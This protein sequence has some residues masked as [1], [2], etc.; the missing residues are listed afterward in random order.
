MTS[1][2]SLSRILTKKRGDHAA[3]SS[4]IGRFGEGIFFLA[5]LLV[6][7]AALLVILFWVTLPNW[8]VNQHFVE[9]ECRIVEAPRAEQRTGGTEGVS[10]RPV[11]P[12]EYDVEGTTYRANNYDLV[13]Q[14]LADR[15]SAESVAAEFQLNET[16]ACWYDPSD[17]SQVVLARWNRFSYWIALLLPSALIAVGAGGLG[18]TVWQAAV[19]RERRAA[20]AQKAADVELFD[21][22]PK[23]RVDYP[24]IPTDDELKNS[25]GTTLAYR[26]PMETSSGWKMFA[27]ATVCVSWNCLVVLFAAVNIGQHLAGQGDWNSTIAVVAFAGAGVWLIYQVVRQLW[28]ASR[29]APTRVEISEHPL[30]PG[31]QCELFVAQ[32]G[33]LAV[34]RFDVL[35]VCEEEATF[36]QGTDTV[37]STE[38]VSAHALFSKEQFEID[39]SAPY[40]VRCAL[41]VPDDAMHSFCADHNNVQWKLLVRS[42]ANC[43][44]NCD[45][46]FPIVVVPQRDC[47]DQGNSESEFKKRVSLNGDI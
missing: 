39:G 24:T 8:R 23:E 28:Q 29:T 10:Y 36:R 13:D 20:L 15:E 6:G 26:L 37:T 43:R 12:F 34:K 40:E 27:L 30:E 19:S 3:I 16:Y 17:P 21:E 33:K 7:A 1:R 44:R 2:F 5:C 9:T 32:S 25:P 45:R 41:R 31:G 22:A 11:I 42:K 18:F 46:S 14:P 38:M 4:R 47:A 35:L